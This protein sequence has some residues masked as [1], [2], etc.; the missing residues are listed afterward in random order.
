VPWE[1]LSPEARVRRVYALLLRRGGRPNPALPARETLESACTPPADAAATSPAL[2]Q[3]RYSAILSLRMTPTIYANVRALKI[4]K[5]GF[6]IA[7]FTRI[8][9]L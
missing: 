7:A 9:S 3:A 1:K 4:K 2:R 8:L 6:P 5:G